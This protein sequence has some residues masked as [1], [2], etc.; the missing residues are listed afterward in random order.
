MMPL[1]VHNHIDKPLIEA[2]W[3]HWMGILTMLK[4]ETCKSIDPAIAALPTGTRV[5]VSTSSKIHL[6]TYASQQIHNGTQ[7]I[8]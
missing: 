4:V 8:K 3:F 7:E 1:I 6:H 5:S 2:V